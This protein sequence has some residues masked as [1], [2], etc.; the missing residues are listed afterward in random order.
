MKLSRPA[1]QAKIE[2][3]KK[4]NCAK[5]IQRSFRGYLSRQAQIEQELEEEAQRQREQKA[6]MAFLSTTATLI[7]RAFRAYLC[8]KSVSQAFMKRQRLKMIVTD[9]VTAWK[10]RRSLN[11]LGSEV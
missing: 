10:T 11:C 6:H 7:Q 1:Q 4:H 3:L 2:F 9:L 5:K 8:R